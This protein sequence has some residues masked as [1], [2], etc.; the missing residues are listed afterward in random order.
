L[1]LAKPEGKK[2]EGAVVVERGHSQVS[3]VPA[4]RLAGL[5]GLHPQKANAKHRFDLS[6]N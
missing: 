5:I 6:M 4:L 3:T 2:R 1:E